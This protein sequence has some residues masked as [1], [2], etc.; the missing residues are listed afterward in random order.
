MQH[1]NRNA[2]MSWSK[3]YDRCLRCGTQTHKHVGR[4]LC[5]YCYRTDIE[6]RHKAHITGG[7]KD[8]K[9]FANISKDELEFQYQSLEMSLSDLALKYNCTRQY[10]HKLMKKYGISERDK[11]TARELAYSKEK[12]IFNRE[13]ELGNKTR[14]LHRR[15]L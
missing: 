14:L 13:D 7:L 12:I 2:N 1:L 5:G 10:I 9:I 15:I 11:A 8:R 4:G 3:K 6:N